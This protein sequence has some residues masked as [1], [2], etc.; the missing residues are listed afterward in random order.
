MS[1][2]LPAATGKSV[3]AMPM[4]L[5]EGRLQAEEAV[6]DTDGG[7]DEPAP[8]G[9]QERQQR[10]GQ[11]HPLAAIRGG[12]KGV[13]AVSETQ[14]DALCPAHDDKS[15]SLS[16][17]QGADGRVLVRCHAG[18][19][20]E[21]VVAALNLKMTDLFAGD[22]GVKPECV[23][24]Y[25][26]EAGHI[27]FQTV[28]YPG[29]Q[30]AARR[31]DGDGAWIWKLGETRRLPYRLPE[32]ITAAARGSRVYAVEGEKDVDTL[33]ELGLVATTNPF[34]AGKW[35]PE[36]SPY[37]TGAEVV[38]VPDADAVGREHAD[39][40]CRS[41][42]P[43][44]A[45]VRILELP[46]AADGE[47][48]TDFVVKRGW[49]G[50]DFEKYADA[51][52][53][54]SVPG[55]EREPPG[56]G[57]LEPESPKPGPSLSSMK[58]I[59]ITDLMKMPDVEPEWLVH[60]L[61]LKEGTSLFV[62]KPKV[63]KTT[64]AR[65]SA[66]AVARGEDFLDRKV[67]K[68]PVLYLSLED[69]ESLVRS[70]F[71]ALGSDAG[72]S[73]FFGMPPPDPFPDLRRLISE[74]RPG[75]VVIDT[76]AKFVHIKDYKDYGEVSHLMQNFQNLAREYGCHVML[77]HHAPKFGGEGID[78]AIGSVAFTGGVDTLVVMTEKRGQRVMTSRQRFGDDL[79]PTSLTYDKVTRRIG[80]GVPVEV[81]EET[82]LRTGILEALPSSTPGKIESDLL[83]EVV[84]DT[85]AKSRVLR[86]LVAEGLVHREGGGKKGS[87][88]LYSRAFPA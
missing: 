75:L 63:G 50:A 58:V 78:A 19:E 74:K 5:Q 62:A 81:A 15:P 85:G 10:V 16:V 57:P 54:Y 71:K 6:S 77:I 83:A 30:F 65:C 79:E 66:A 33:R 22:P 9:E 48:S 42:L 56:E 73:F 18:C 34:G 69:G 31:P 17:G 11:G 28:R 49:V 87:P 61:L 82:R 72:I 67:Q 46:D 1:V 3:A 35:K 70:H 32:V 86:A 55:P 51:A 84:G 23:Y 37:L 12:L 14:F 36:F 21:E 52:P 39:S 47:D 64:V 29:K 60:G 26:D 44:A 27:L 40:V 53:A 8:P 24:D 4:G 13:K 20:T 68:A 45:S 2:P 59:D 88:F 25:E 7:L 76:V 43:Y 41:L 80:L 38:V